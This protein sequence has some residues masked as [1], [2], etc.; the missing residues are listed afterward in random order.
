MVGDTRRKRDRLFGQ[1][2][3]EGRDVTCPR[4]RNE[5][6]DRIDTDRLQKGISLKWINM[7]KNATKIEYTARLLSLRCRF[8]PYLHTFSKPL[9]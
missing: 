5:A 2:Q 8:S 9:C 3:A 1:E 7:E 4:P 6:N